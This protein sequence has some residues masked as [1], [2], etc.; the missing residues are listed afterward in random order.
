MP[1]SHPPFG[2][3]ILVLCSYLGVFDFPACAPSAAFKPKNSSAGA[4]FIPDIVPGYL[5]QAL[6]YPFQLSTFF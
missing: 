3:R 6:R 2:V 1:L 4:L 5:F